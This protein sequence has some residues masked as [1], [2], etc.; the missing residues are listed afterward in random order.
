MIKT[1]FFI[2]IFLIICNL[3]SHSQHYIDSTTT[4]LKGGTNINV[5]PGDTIYLEAGH[6]PYLLLENIVGKPDSII[7]IINYQGKV[8]INTNHYFGISTKGC[9][10]FKITGTGINTIDYGIDIQK[11]EHGTGI[12]LTGLSNHF[13][14]D[15][16]RI[17]NTLLAGIYAKTDPDTTFSSV[18]DSFL[19]EDIYIHHNLLENITDEG[20]YIGSTKYFGQ[21]ISFNGGDTLLFPHLL[22]NVDISFNKIM[23]TGWDGIQLSSASQDAAIHDNIIINDSYRDYPNQMS[24]LMVGGGTKAEVYNNYISGGHGSGIVL[25]SLGGQR[26]Y[27]NIIIDAG[28]NYYPNDITLMQHGIYVDDVTIQ[29]DSSFLIFNNLIA[30]PKSDGIR[31]R[32]LLSKNNKIANNVIINPGNYGYYDTLHT[33]F[34]AKDAFIMLTDK[35]IDVDTFSNIWVIDPSNLKFTDPINHN[36]TLLSNSPLIDAGVNLIN[37]GIDID[38]YNHGRPYGLGFDIGPFEYN[39]FYQGINKSQLIN[40]FRIFPNPAHD[41]IHI[42]APSNIPFYKVQIYDINGKRIAADSLQMQEIQSKTVTIN[43]STLTKGT[44]LLKVIS[45]KTNKTIKFIKL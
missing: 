6:K 25:V 44:Y 23:N 37:Y 11:V 33:S 8:I 24:G 39:S 5:Q 20:M 36:F 43:I 10:Y 1:Y 29:P 16:I 13:E 19:M 18:R 40:N 12:G 27:N 31:F 45:E 4:Y 15:H 2:F 30:N 28:K 17:S 34:M 41:Y 3:E 21:H 26:I 22:H 35:N 14:V 38:F 42:I 9:D 32:S 7:V